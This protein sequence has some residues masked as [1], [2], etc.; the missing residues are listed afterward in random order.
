LE[1]LRKTIS[2]P[3]LLHGGIV[4]AVRRR[5]RP[6]HNSMTAT[7]RPW[8]GHPEPPLARDAGEAATRSAPLR[9]A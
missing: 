4:S 1:A 8:P 3:C 6:G 2:R 5:R 7:V 9:P